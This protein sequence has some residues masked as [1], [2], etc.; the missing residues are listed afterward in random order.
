MSVPYVPPSCPSCEKP[1]F[2]VY[3]LV[4]EVYVFNAQTGRYDGPVGET[5][6]IRCST[7]NCKLWE[8][9]PDGACNYQATKEAM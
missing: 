2:T 4:D 7:C 5:M 3:E 9:L 8:A 1:L 6:E